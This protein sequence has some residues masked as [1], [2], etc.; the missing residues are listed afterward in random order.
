MTVRTPSTIRNRWIH[1][2]LIFSD[3][4]DFIENI[5]SSAGIP[6][7]PIKGSY[8]IAAGI[9]S[10]IP[11]RTM[12][13]IDILVRPENFHET[14]S[15]LSD[16]PHFKKDAPDL[17]F[18]EQTFKITRNK[19]PLYFEL[20][21]Q[22]NRE[23]RFHLSADSLFNRGTAQTPERVLPSP[24]DAMVIL[25]GHSLVHSGKGLQSSIFN[26][27]TEISALKDFCW[28]RFFT[29]LK[30]T[31]IEPYGFALLRAYSRKTDMP[32]PIPDKH[33][34][35]DILF[36][37][38][39]QRNKN[40]T[41]YRLWYRGFIEPV[42]SRSPVKLMFGWTLRTLRRKFGKQ[43]QPDGRRLAA[44][45]YHRTSAMHCTMSAAAQDELLHDTPFR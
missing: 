40:S 9:A 15:L 45:A 30:N 32:V 37:Q 29:I 42:F 27:I 8:L 7:M 28:Q 10:Q 38:V 22:I 34:W 41:V 17:W 19:D 26:E 14:I 36:R 33:R 6:Y 25:V 12:L 44:E 23:E 39:P 18:F 4:L 3:I 13:D 16:H 24:E 1:Q 21:C 31:G 5:F 11:D 20:H 2:Q 35:A 43:L